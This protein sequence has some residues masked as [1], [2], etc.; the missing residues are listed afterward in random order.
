MAKTKLKISHLNITD[1]LIL[2][3]TK[4]RY[5]LGEEEFIYVELETVLIMGC[6]TLVSKL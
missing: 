4:H 1:H 2:G 5:E 6:P 3:I